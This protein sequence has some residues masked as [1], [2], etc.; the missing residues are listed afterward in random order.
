MGDMGDYWRGHREYKRTVRSFWHECPHC[1]G[2]YGTG[3]KTPPGEA[4]RNCGWI[5]PGERG[6]DIVCAQSK[7]ADE[8][9]AAETRAAEK[10]ARRNRSILLRTCGNCGK[11]FKSERARG[12]HQKDKHG[13]VNR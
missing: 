11:V 5:A 4:C 10:A 1:A 8:A 9:A 12:D 2:M 3:T 7:L 6:S 13:G